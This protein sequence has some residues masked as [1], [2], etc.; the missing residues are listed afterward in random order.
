MLFFYIF[1]GVAFLFG[2]VFIL[3]RNKKS[4]LEKDSL[5]KQIALEK[6]YYKKL[7]ESQKLI[8]TMRTDI[9]SYIK[10]M[11]E[12]GKPEN[13]MSGLMEKYESI[14][15]VE[16]SRHPVVNA[17]AYDKMN[18][19]NE[20]GVK[21]EYDFMV[22]PRNGISDMD[23]I[24]LMGNLLD[25]A[26]EAT[27]K[28]PETERKVLFTVKEKKGALLFCCK[29]RKSR[30]EEPLR[31]GFSTSKPNSFFH[32]LGRKIIQEIVEKYHGVLEDRDMGEWMET[33]ILLIN[34]G[35]SL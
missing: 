20:L 14:P 32:G 19:A 23:L 10:E 4:L 11:R 30:E 17:V 9:D 16:F 18:K 6:E 2:V 26:L 7:E 24:S 5:E 1:A 28:L 3:Y 21:L 33:E 12:M 25:N 22:T 8:Q 31:K 13:V 15:Q 29:N 27:Q 35:E 34:G